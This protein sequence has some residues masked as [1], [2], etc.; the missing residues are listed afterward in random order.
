MNILAFIIDE[1]II[2]IVCFLIFD[3]LF[4]SLSIYIIVVLRIVINIAQ[5]VLVLGFWGVPYCILAL[6]VRVL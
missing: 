5:R 4:I 3:I 6:C 1:Y 2:I